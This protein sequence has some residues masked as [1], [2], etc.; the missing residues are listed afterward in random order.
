MHLPGRIAPKH[1]KRRKSDRPVGMIGGL[2]PAPLVRRAMRRRWV[3]ALLA[4]TINP[5]ARATIFAGEQ[6]MHAVGLDERAHRGAL[7]ELMGIRA[8]HAR[9]KRVNL[10]FLARAQ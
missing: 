5:R 4:G 2:A 10:L 3:Q 6:G 1:R 7:R 8:S 9:G